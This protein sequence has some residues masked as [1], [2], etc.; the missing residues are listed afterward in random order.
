[1][2]Y[3]E[4]EEKLWRAT[5]SI[6]DDEIRQVVSFLLKQE[7]P[8]YIKAPG[9]AKG[10]HHDHINGQGEH[11]C[12]MI[13]I[14]NSLE[15]VLFQKVVHNHDVVRACII[16]HDIQKPYQFIIG[17]DSWEKVQTD[18]DHFE[19]P[20]IRIEAACLE[21]GFNPAQQKFVD[22]MA[23]VRTHHGDFA[24]TAPDRAE[25]RIVA[26]IDNMSAK[27]DERAAWGV[28]IHFLPK[29]LINDFLKNHVNK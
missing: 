11:L 7:M 4:I 29:Q 9:S 21:L 18:K 5:D 24:P 20:A 22:M 12:E 28:R 19:Y 2:T 17:D 13:D 14:Y 25:A 27:I 3:E 8:N 15:N 23:V 1:M 6:N 16:I 26:V 10:F